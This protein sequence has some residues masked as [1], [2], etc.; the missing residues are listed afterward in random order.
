MERKYLPAELKKW[1]NRWMIVFYQINPST[2]ERQRF[3][4]SF[5]LNRI[6]DFFEKEKRAAE[7][8]KELNE[9]LL[10]KG[11]PFFEPEKKVKGL[12]S[13]PIKQALEIAALVK[14]QGRAATVSAYRYSS[15]VFIEFLCHNEL[16]KVGVG[17]FSPQM[18]LRFLDW[19]VLDKKLSNVSH[20]NLGSKLRTMF[21][22]LKERE[23]INEN[24]FSG[25]KK[26]VEEQKERRPLS[27][28]EKEILGAYIKEKDPRLYLAVLLMYYCFIR[29]SELLRLKFRYFDFRNGVIRMPGAK[30]KNRKT[31]T[32]TIPKELIKI[33]KEDYYFNKYPGHWLVFGKGMNPNV[34]PCSRNTPT[35]RHRKLVNDLGKKGRLSDCKG[36]HFYSWKDTG[37]MN[38]VEQ[39]VDI[40]KIQQ[41]LRH[42]SLHTTQKYLKMMAGKIDIISDLTL[43]I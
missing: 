16:D 26:R 43:D 12:S 30:T 4:R 40:L 17:E 27:D 11:Y 19:I 8:L 14:M 36:I 1:G 32:V 42:S 9:D 29:K 39:N 28:D 33:L 41:Q 37:A 13:T 5:D 7:L 2:N 20:N 15:N 31:E 23:Y 38:L 22:V 18:A 35:T 6:S 25:F 24:P 21:E 3:A 34:S 10:P